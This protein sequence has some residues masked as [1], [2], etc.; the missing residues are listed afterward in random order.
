MQIT[1]RAARVN[2][3][4]TQQEAADAIGTTKDIISNWERGVSFPNVLM[5][6][7]IEEVYG[8]SYKDILFF[9][10]EYRLKRNY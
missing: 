5:L 2:K 3:G 1:L 7:K 6:Q 4:Y 9:T 10:R 8:V